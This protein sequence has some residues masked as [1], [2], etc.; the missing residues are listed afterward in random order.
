MGFGRKPDGPVSPLADSFGR[1]LMQRRHQLDVSVKTA[2]DR[3]GLS[4]FTLS[5]ME[6][7]FTD[8]LDIRV[9]TLKKLSLA[10]AVK[11]DA[12]LWRMGVM[13]RPY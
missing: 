13:P 2:A 4:T 5:Y 12:L 3:A 7:G 1:F 6:R 8:P 10:Y 9:G 11:V